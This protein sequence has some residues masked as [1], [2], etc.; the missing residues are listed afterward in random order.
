[1]LSGPT[2]RLVVKLKSQKP[3]AAYSSGDTFINVNKLTEK[4]GA[5]YEKLRYL[6]DYKDERHIRRSAIERII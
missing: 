5:A 1:M 2:E 4:A 3:I 6:I